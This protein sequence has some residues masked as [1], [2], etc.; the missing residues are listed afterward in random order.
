MRILRGNLLNTLREKYFND[1]KD[2]SK[3]FK[4]RKPGDIHE[5]KANTW[6]LVD[7]NVFHQYW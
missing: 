4:G 1:A 5:V 6:E 2:Y 7:I 3:D